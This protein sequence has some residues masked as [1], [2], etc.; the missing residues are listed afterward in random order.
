MSYFNYLNA[1]KKNRIFFL[2]PAENI[3][4]TDREILAYA[5][6]ATLYMP[7]SSPEIFNK[8]SKDPV[9]GLI[10][11]VLCLEDA[12]GDEDVISAENNMIKQLSVLYQAK[13]VDRPPF[14]FVRV[15]NLKQMKRLVKKLRTKLSVLTGFVF[16]KFEAENGH[17]YFEELRQINKSLATPLLGM[18]ILEVECIIKL[19]T[20]IACLLKIKEILDSYKDLVL[21]VRIGATDLS[22]QYSIRRGH[23]FTIYDIAVIRDCIADII[24]IFGMATDNYVISGPVWEYFSP[25]HRVLKP[26]LRSSP[27]YEQHGMLGLQLRQKLICSH[28]DGLIKEVM[29]DKAN[30]LVGKTVIHP[31]HLVPVQALCAVTHEEYSD[32]ASIVQNNNG[33]VFKSSYNNKMNEVKPHTNWAKK[34]M[35]LSKIYGVLKEN[36]D[37]THIIYAK[38]DM[39]NIKHPLC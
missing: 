7:A 32:A 26:Q 6:G 14:I 20:R 37:Y 29:I 35:T 38:E 39:Q 25:G 27:F 19:E 34:V 15:R 5:L 3:L 12:V 8:L 17:L 33:G 36:H 23:E 11:T 13:K 4:N 30:G 10:S 2:S 28:V 24:N 18:P 21:N 22:G 9:S 31:S 1:E 16:P